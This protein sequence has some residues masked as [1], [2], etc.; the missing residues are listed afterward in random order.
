M[1]TLSLPIS[2]M[3]DLPPPSPRPPRV[4]TFR[5]PIPEHTLDGW[6]S[7]IAVDSHG[8]IALATVMGHSLLASSP[9]TMGPPTD[10]G[11]YSQIPRLDIISLAND[12][13]RRAKDIRRLLGSERRRP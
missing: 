7:K 11:S 1:G 5:Y 9:P 3:P 12:I 2:I 10:P 13:R 4:P 6:K 8:A